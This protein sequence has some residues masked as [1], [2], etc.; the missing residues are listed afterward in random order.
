MATKKKP[1][2][3]GKIMA[4]FGLG[5][6]TLMGLT[7]GTILLTQ[8]PSGGG[9][10]VVKQTYAPPPI[11]TQAI[12]N[13]EALDRLKLETQQSLLAASESIQQMNTQN[14]EQFA[15]LNQRMEALEKNLQANL[16]KDK[17]VAVLRPEDKPVK[18]RGRNVVKPPETYD[19]YKVEAIIG[20]VVW[21]SGNGLESAMPV[22]VGQRVP[23][24]PSALTA[25]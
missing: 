12:M 11:N 4:F 13:T 6:V 7:M 16:L 10:Q 1:M 18:P 14:A 25:Q 17:R 20:D 21:V 19:G 24:Q 5:L 2:S 8:K 22:R 9:K 23:A 3:M 15:A